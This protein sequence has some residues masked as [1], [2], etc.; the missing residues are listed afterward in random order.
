MGCPQV[1][2]EYGGRESQS[3]LPEVNGNGGWPLAV[4]SNSEVSSNCDLV[5]IQIFEKVGQKGRVS[6][7]G[8]SPL[9]FFRSTHPLL[10]SMHCLIFSYGA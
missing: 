10:C 1:P 7:E 6:R 3:Q 8:N 9:R 2:E 4:L 5:P